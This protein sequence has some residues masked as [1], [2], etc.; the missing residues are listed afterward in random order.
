MAESELKQF[1]IT[2]LGDTTYEWAPSRQSILEDLQRMGA[3]DKDTVVEEATDEEVESARAA[4]APAQRAPDR[5]EEQFFTLPDGQKVKSVGGVL[6][7]LKWREFTKR[8]MI[9]RLNSEDMKF[10]EGLDTLEVLDWVELKP[11]GNEDAS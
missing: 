10:P 6:Y 7:G 3:L 9:E 11:E 8:D 2:C 4:P 1:R 5:A